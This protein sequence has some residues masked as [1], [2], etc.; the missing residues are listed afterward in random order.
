MQDKDRSV[1][2]RL[3]QFLQ[4]GQALFGE[5]E[6]VPAADHAHPL[7]SRRAIGL[8]LEHAQRIGQG[9]HAFPAQFEVVVQAATD[10]VQVRVIKARDDTAPLEVDD[11]GARTAQGHCLSIGADGHKAAIAD[12]HG[13]G[14]GVFA[15]DGI[16]LAIE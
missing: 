4:G 1:R 9:W 3:V 16:K 2:G 13:T 14:M 15:I 12:G 6:F 11:L 8:I 5:L 7:R 10:Q